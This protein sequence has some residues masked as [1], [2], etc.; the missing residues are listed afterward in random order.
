LATEAVGICLFGLAEVL[1][2]YGSRLAWRG[3]VMA[4]A[5]G[6]W[7]KIGASVRHKS[8]SGALTVAARSLTGSARAQ[9]CWQTISHMRNYLL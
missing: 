7:E 4:A 3:S 8:G 1:I 5:V 9:S 2:G 6:R